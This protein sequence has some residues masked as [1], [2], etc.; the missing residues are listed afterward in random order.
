MGE[1]KK[2]KKIPRKTE[3]SIS[4]LPSFENNGLWCI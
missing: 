1:L 3:E 2:K 4:F